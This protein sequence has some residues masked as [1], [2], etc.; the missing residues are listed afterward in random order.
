MGRPSQSGRSHPPRFGD[1]LVLRQENFRDLATVARD[2]ALPPSRRV[3]DSACPVSAR[4]RRPRFRVR[5]WAARYALDTSA[6]SGAE[7]IPDR[8]R[9][10][11]A[12]SAAMARSEGRQHAERSLPPDDG[13][14]LDA[15]DLAAL[16]GGRQHESKPAARRPRDTGFRPCGIAFKRERSGSGRFAA[17]VVAAAGRCLVVSATCSRIGSSRA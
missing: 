16:R 10:V 2:A 3:V 15:E 1:S 14:A 9:R 13:A 11:T 17:A 4:R 12:L 7:L 6:E 5:A 8:R